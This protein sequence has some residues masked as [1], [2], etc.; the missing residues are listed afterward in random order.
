MQDVLNAFDEYLADRGMAFEGTA[1]GGAALIVL[2]VI[3]R[4]TRDVDVLEPQIPEGIRNAARAFAKMHP[5]L[6]V[7]EQW[8]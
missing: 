1:I 6:N 3:S 2:G 7:D 4:A 8:S 5:E